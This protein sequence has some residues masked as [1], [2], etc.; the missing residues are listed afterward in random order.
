MSDE[1]ESTKSSDPT[2]LKQHKSRPM[3]VDCSPETKDALPIAN[4]FSD[5][6][7]A[8]TKSHNTNGGEEID[9]VNGKT[10]PVADFVLDADKVSKTDYG[11]SSEI[12]ME[13][14]PVSE[15]NCDKKPALTGN[16][17]KS[18]SPTLPPDNV[19]AKI[20]SYCAPGP[21]A[22]GSGTPTKPGN[23]NN[24]VATPTNPIPHSALNQRL[25]ETISRRKSGNAAPPAATDVLPPSVL[26]QYSYKQV[27]FLCGVCVAP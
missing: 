2:A 21:S 4:G 19:R 23:E 17:R 3:I 26:H 9:G 11:K 7:D 1:S 27:S 24:V 5:A 12:S 8:E 16:K 10:E 20:S 15:S 25:K 22:N 14:V 6:T 18:D 13:V